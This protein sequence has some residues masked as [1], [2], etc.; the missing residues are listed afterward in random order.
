M[1]IDFSKTFDSI[2]REKMEQ[3][4]VVSIKKTVTAIMI[5]YKNTK[6]IVSLPDGDTNFFNIAAGGLQW[7]TLVPYMFIVC[8]DY[9]LRTSVDLKKEN[10]FTLKKTKNRQYPTEIMTDVYYAYNLA[11]LT[12]TPTQAELLL[13]NDD[14]ASRGIGLSVN[15]IEFMCFKQIASLWN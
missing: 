6:A 13:L 10:G 1:F 3:M 7:D 8:L 12:N 15:R 5:L 9:V 11:F 2:H 14:R 4:R